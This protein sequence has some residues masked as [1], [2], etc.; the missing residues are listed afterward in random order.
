MGSEPEPPVVDDRLFE[1]AT[2]FATALTETVRA[3]VPD[4]HA[5]VPTIIGNLVS[6]RQDPAEGIILSVDR[7]PLFQL[8]ASYQCRMDR[9][10]DYL[11]I[12]KSGFEV[13]P[14]SSSEPLMRF[15]YERHNRSAPVAHAHVHAPRDAFDRLFAGSGTNT[16]KAKKRAKNDKHSQIQSLHFPLGGHRFRPCLE[17]ILETLIDEFSVDTQPGTMSA[18]AAGREKW[19]RTQTKAV[20]RDDPES[21][22]EM[23]SDLGYDVEW[24][25]AEPEPLVHWERLRKH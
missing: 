5:F 15:E 3:V 10:G 7:E 20:V 17:D 23:L 24:K 13:I 11:A 9:H 6:I 8:K 1:Q 18:L 21:A 2:E 22:I 12:L 19:R 4:S 16:S 14:H 25:S